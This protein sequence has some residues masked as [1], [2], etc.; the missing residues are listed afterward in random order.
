MSNIIIRVD[1]NE[2]GICS[3]RQT[4]VACIPLQAIEGI[5]ADSTSAEKGQ[6]GMEALAFEPLSLS[7]ENMCYYVTLPKG[8]ELQLLKEVTGAF[9]PGVLTALVGVSGAG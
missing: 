7:F 4:S 8:G 5:H 9:R 6:T 1:E 2:S 3:K